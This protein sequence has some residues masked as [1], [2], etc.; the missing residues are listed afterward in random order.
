[1]DKVETMR[2][3]LVASHNAN[4]IKEFRSIFKGYP[5][6]LVSLADLGDKAEVI[7]KGMSFKDNARLKALY[8]ARKHDMITVAD[9]SGIVVE[10]LDG[11]PGI[12]SA[13]YSG[14]GDMQNNQ[15]I[16]REMEGRD[17]RKA[18]FF[19]AIALCFPDGTCHDYTGRVDGLI[20]KEE[21]GEKGFGYDPIFYSETYQM[22]FAELD[23]K[24]KNKI[25]HRA[26]AL[27]RLKEELDDILDHQ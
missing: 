20:A 25:S 18:H 21:K 26:I 4:K 11:Q 2:K 3:I 12:Y 8:F 1:M 6:E 7:E 16:L 27:A 9:D 23:S 5:V 10:A 24:I 19:A 14:K 13:R 17:N 15:K 22:T